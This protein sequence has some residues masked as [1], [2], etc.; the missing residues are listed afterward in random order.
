[1]YGRIGPHQTYISV[2]IEPKTEGFPSVF[3]MV[4]SRN[5]QPFREKNVI[6]KFLSME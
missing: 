6:F 5:H 2:S 4:T 1:M 3:S